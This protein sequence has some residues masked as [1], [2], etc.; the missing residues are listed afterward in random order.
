MTAGQVIFDPLLPWPVVWAAAALM[1][2]VVALA[3]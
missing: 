3:L 1:V 2:A